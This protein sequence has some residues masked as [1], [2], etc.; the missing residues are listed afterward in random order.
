MNYNNQTI[1][2]MPDD[3]NKSNESE[4]IWKSIAGRKIL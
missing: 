3:N 1:I 4:N 2:V